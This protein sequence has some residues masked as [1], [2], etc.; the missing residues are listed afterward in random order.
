MK[1]DVKDAVP[2]GNTGNV[3]VSIVENG[4]LHVPMYKFYNNLY[5]MANYV[6]HREPL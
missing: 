6:R 4:F 5:I 1:R 2:Y 3:C